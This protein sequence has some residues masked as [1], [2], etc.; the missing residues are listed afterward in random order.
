MK[1]GTIDRQTRRKMADSDPRLQRLMV[2]HHWLR[3][4]RESSFTGFFTGLAA[5]SETGF[6]PVNTRPLLANAVSADCFTLATMSG[7]ARLKEYQHGFDMFAKPEA[8]AAEI[9]AAA[10]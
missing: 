2:R 3:T 10:H 4:A 1:S 9:H 8:F 6:C 5:R 7:M